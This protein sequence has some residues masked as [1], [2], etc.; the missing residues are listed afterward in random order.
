MHSEDEFQ[1]HLDDHPDDHAA[2]MIFADWLDEQGDLRGPG[3]RWMGANWKMAKTN[4]HIWWIS[5]ESHT[6]DGTEGEEWKRLPDDW[7]YLIPK[8]DRDGTFP[9]QDESKFWRFARSRQRLEDAAALAFSRLPASRQAE[10]L[11]PASASQPATA[12]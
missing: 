2:R 10:L 3:Y 8:I 11:T 6:S 4:H 12:E 7:F 9:D 5:R 1:A